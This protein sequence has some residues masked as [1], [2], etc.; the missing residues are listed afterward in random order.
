MQ[1][2]DFLPDHINTHVHR[3]ACPKC[4]AHMMLTR[5]MPARVGFDLR[6]FECPKCDHVHEV[7]VENNAF[8]MSFT[9]RR[10][11]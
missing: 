8:G 4:R 7:M 11:G 3:P 1:K 6:T 9:P 10:R 5:I 2:S